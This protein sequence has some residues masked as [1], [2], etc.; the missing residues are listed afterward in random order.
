MHVIRL[1]D[2]DNSALRQNLVPILEKSESKVY[3]MLSCALAFEAA[4]RELGGDADNDNDDDGAEA[5]SL[6]EEAWRRLQLAL[7]PSSHGNSLGQDDENRDDND[8]DSSSLK[9]ALKMNLTKKEAQSRLSAE[10]F[11]LWKKAQ[12]SLRKSA[13]SNYYNEDGE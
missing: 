12:R 5:E 2:V 6:V 11:K 13:S 8:D 3:S 9:A 7:D 1:S 10:D 4:I